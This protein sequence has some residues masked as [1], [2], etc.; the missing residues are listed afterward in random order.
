LS[1]AAPNQRMHAAGA[2]AISKAAARGNPTLPA[3]RS[4]SKS[5]Y[6]LIREGLLT[7]MKGG[8]RGP[9]PHHSTL[10]G[11]PGGSLYHG[12]G[13]GPGTREFLDLCRLSLIGNCRHR[14]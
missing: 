3:G 2:R 5:G 4:E 14:N 13:E 1:L 7:G 11:P 9:R 10:V 8:G 12:I 6:Q